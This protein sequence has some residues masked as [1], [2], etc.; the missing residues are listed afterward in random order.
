MADNKQNPVQ[1]GNKPRP[2]GTSGQSAKDKS[3]AAS[4]PVTTKAGGGKGGNTPRPG[5]AAASGPKGPKGPRTGMLMAWGAVGLVVVIIAVFAIV[6]LTGSSQDTSYTAV[7]PAPAQVVQ[8]VTNIPMSTWNKVGVTSQFPVNKPVI[9]SGQPPL[10]IAG[11]TPT[12]F[13]LGAEYCPF[14]AAERWAMTAAL[15]RFGTWSNLKITASSHTDVDPITHT[16]SYHGATLD[17]PYLHFVSV[18]QCTNVPDPSNPGCSGYTNLEHLT[19]EELANATKYSSAQFIPGAS[20]SI[21]FP[22]VNIDNL[23]LISGASYDPQ[24]LAG[25]SWTDIAGSLYDPTNPTTQAIVTTGNYMSAAI[26]NATKGQ[27]GNVCTSSG[28]QAAAKALGISAS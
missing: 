27:P 24:I 7:T 8:D 10:T 12:M 18:E 28:V 23:A 13:Y 16:F 6:K 14:C 4:R 26:C 9:T 17:S 3:R 19:Q 5:K 21:S 11:K 20:G 22:F 1:G 25:Q 15:S 2:T